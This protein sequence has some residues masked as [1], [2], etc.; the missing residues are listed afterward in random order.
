MNGGILAAAWD[1][2]HAVTREVFEFYFIGGLSLQRW[3]EPRFTPAVDL[4][5]LCPF[6]EEKEASR[7][8][9]QYLEPRF[10]GAIDFS[11]ESR[12]F[13]G[14]ADNGVPVD[15]AYSAINYEICCVERAGR[16]DFGEDIRLRTCSAE[17]LVIMKTFADR[18]RDWAD[19]EG[20]ILR[21]G[22][23]LDWSLIEAELMPL[24]AIRGGMDLWNRLL[25]LR[26]QF[27]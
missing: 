22:E 13:L 11:A 17:D 8:L 27:P 1:V 7:R 21:Q 9:A 24:L 20:I 10:D 19:I 25:D 23:E 26:N 3:G 15:I 2:Q 12:V 16:F 5:L 6:G 14:R 18:S 4:T